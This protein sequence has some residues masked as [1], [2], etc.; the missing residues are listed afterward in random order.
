MI[1][2]VMR[3]YHPEAQGAAVAAALFGLGRISGI[4][5]PAIA[6]PIPSLTGTT[7]VLDS[8]AKV[9]AKPEHMVQSAIM[10]AF[11]LS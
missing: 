6:T 8:G 3:W 2:S 10:A 7:V 1:K 9:D 5:R 4:E 11:M